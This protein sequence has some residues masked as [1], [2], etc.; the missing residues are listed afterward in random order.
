VHLFRLPGLG[1]ILGAP[2]SGQGRQAAGKDKQGPSTMAAQ[3]VCAH[4]SGLGL[5]L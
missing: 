4:V 1:A 3:E 5:V 2:A